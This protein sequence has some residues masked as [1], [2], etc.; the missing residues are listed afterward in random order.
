MR[1]ANPEKVFEIT[2]KILKLVKKENFEDACPAL[3]FSLTLLPTG[4]QKDE[5]ERKSNM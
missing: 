1:A 3:K 2:R 5:I 4:A